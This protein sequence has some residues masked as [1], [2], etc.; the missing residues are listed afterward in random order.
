MKHFIKFTALLTAVILL[1]GTV[2][3]KDSYQNAIIYY[4]VPERPFTLDAQTASTDSELSIV[5]NIYEG[6][7]RKN[8]SG[9]VVCGAA[10]S[11]EKNGLKYTFK[12]RENGVWSNKEPL[13]AADFVFGLRRAVTP[14]TAAPFA[15]R[16][17]AIKNAKEIGNGKKS[18]DTLGVSA[19]DEHTVIIELAYD[20]PSFEE[21]LTTSV[22]MPCNEKFF[23]ESGG[24]YGLT[25]NTVISCGSYRL[26]R[27][28]DDENSFGIRIYSFE[29]Y[30]GT[31]KAKNSAVYIT[32]T[33]DKTPYERLCDNNVDITFI[34][35]AL[36]DNAK[37]AG[38]KA[39][40]YQNIC[41][42]MTMDSSLSENFRKSLAMLIGEQVYSADLKPGYSAA[43]SLFPGVISGEKSSAGMLSYNADGAK[44]LYSAELKKQTD[45]KFPS[46]I[47]LYFYDNGVIKPIIT[48]IV[49][50]WQNKLGAFINI[51]TASSVDKLTPQLKSRDLPIAVFPIRADSES[52]SEFSEKFGVSASGKT[53]DA[54]QSEL[55]RGTSIIPLLFQNTTIAY[56]D[57]LSDVYTVPGDGYIDF[58]FIVKQKIKGM[59]MVR[60]IKALAQFS[61]ISHSHNLAVLRRSRLGFCCYLCAC[62]RL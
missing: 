32:C 26:G 17:F 16:L 41:W 15:S 42:V 6:L 4:E 3:C 29:S 18:A 37:A 25:L 19:P 56:S 22:A 43:A 35:S 5:K 53:A 48:D 33:K 24:K 28:N 59:Y 57:A 45:K 8:S 44:T 7:L 14:A 2:G 11:F 21:A 9:A 55:L 36:S 39:T 62:L 52:L 38:L 10:E 27:W 30:K 20:D 51:E 46:D 31:F 61:Q 23:N 49:G 40:N 12:L 47:K 58:S 13:T 1:L 34:D 50:H 60:H 54:V